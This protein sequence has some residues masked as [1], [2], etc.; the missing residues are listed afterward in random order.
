MKIPIEI[1][2]KKIMIATEIKSIHEE[3]SINVRLILDTGATN[4][5]ISHEIAKTLGY[6]I[7]RPNKF[8]VID[9]AGGSVIQPCITI[10]SIKVGSE[11]IDNL[12]NVICNLQFDQQGINGIL[13]MDFLIKYNF[14]I[15][16]EEKFV[17]L[18]KII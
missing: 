10:G 3:K 8:V 13:G 5:A 12:D 15:N 7:L 11:E 14:L 17:E 9:T 2:D 18:V 6:N 4:T 1:Q 16:I